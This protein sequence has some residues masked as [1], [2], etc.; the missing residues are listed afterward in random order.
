M[1]YHGRK[2]E[3]MVNEELPSLPFEHASA[4]LFS[5]QGWEYLIYADRL[6]G[7]TCLVKTG[8]TTS[9]RDVVVHICRWFAEVGVPSRLRTHGGPQFSSRS[10]RS[11][12]PAVASAT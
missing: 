5:C 7:W 1:D 2:K 3:P 8:R 12:L 9:S 11:F 4:D 6:T 10:F